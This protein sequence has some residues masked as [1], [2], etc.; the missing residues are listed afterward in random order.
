MFKKSFLKQSG[1]FLSDI[2]EITSDSYEL[3][4]HVLEAVPN[5][6]VTV[7]TATFNQANN[8]ERCMESILMQE[9]T[10][11]FEYIIGEDCSTDG[12]REIVFKYAEKYPD[13]IRVITADRN[14]GLKANNYRCRKATRGEFTALCE[15][16]DYWTDPQKLQKQINYLTEHPECDLCFH[17]AKIVYLDFPGMET[18]TGNRAKKNC[19]IP[20]KNLIFSNGDYCPTASLVVRTSINNLLGEW[21]LDAPIG[22]YYYQIL[23]AS[24]GGALYL[25]E[26]MSVYN[27]SSKGTWGTFNKEMQKDTA[28]SYKH[29]LTMCNRLRIFDEVMDYRLHKWLKKRERRIILHA[30]LPFYLFE[31]KRREVIMNVV[32]KHSNRSVTFYCYCIIVFSFVYHKL[33]VKKLMP[34][35]LKTES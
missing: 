25:N 31:R 20:V 26:I 23:G 6:K 29:L 33:N 35:F 22:D 27:K 12:T 11:D 34:H 32:K 10:F 13:I 3:S 17:P 24:R 18:I 19:I 1:E 7:R 9:T 8:I 16:D 21:Y 15:G 4:N 14:L 5:P 2:E 30:F 28:K